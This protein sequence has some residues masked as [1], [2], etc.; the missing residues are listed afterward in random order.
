LGDE[1]IKKKR[2]LV[3]E[4][5]GLWY[6]KLGVNNVKSKVKAKSSNRGI[7]FWKRGWNSRTVQ[8]KKSKKYQKQWKEDGDDEEETGKCKHS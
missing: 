6:I 1:D 2:L 8:R 5:S 7:F 4:P 3:R